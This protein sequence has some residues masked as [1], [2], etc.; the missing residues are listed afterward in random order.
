VDD[1]NAQLY[2][3]GAGILPAMLRPPT[4]ADGSESTSLLGMDLASPVFQFL[5]GR[6]EIPSATISRHFPATP[7]QVDAR[8][9][10]SY[11]NNDPFLIEGESERG[12]VLLVTT[13][14]DADW[15]TLPLSNFYLPFVQSAVRYLAAGA[16]ADGNLAAGYP[17][18]RTFDDANPA[19]SASITR[20]DGRTIRLDVVRL[21]KQAEV[22]YN[23]TEQPGEYRLDVRESGKPAQTF[24]YVV[25]PSREESDLTQLTEDRWTSLEH[26]LGFTRIDPSGRPISEALAANREGRE[27]WGAALAAVL[28]LAVLE[29]LVAR[30]ASV[31]RK[32]NDHRDGFAESE[33]SGRP[34]LVG[35]ALADAGD[36]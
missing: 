8:P 2:R 7:R 17:I 6:F 11:L 15:S 30:M 1:Y 24:E 10:A 23:D 19:R 20:P 12:C 4:A 3:D 33:R 14:L 36:R 25:R 5:R 32:Q 29:M 16:V 9:L 18:R 31:R 27:L 13:P 28:I 35:S 26:S 34:S 22:R 21:E